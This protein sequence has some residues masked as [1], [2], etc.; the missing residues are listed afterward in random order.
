MNANLLLVETRLLSLSFERFI[1]GAWDQ[2]EGTE[3]IPG[4]HVALMARHLQAAAKG[5]IS[6]LLI[7]VPPECTKS[8]VV[9][10]LF[11]A[12]VWSWKPEARFLYQSYSLEFTLRDATNSRRLVESVWYRQRWPHVQL[13]EDDNRKGYYRTTAGGYRLSTTRGSRVT[14]EHPDFILFEDPLSVDQAGSK[15]EREA[16]K[17]W[18]R[19]TISSRGVAR[20]AAHILSQQRLHPDDPSSVAVEQNKQALGAGDVPPWHHVCL[21]MRF[22]QDRAM[23]DRGYGGDWR[24]TDGELLFPQVF[25][26]EKVK[27]NERSMGP[28]ATRAQLQQ[29]PQHS[30]GQMFAVDRLTANTIDAAPLKLD[31]VVRGWDRAASKDSGCYSAGVLLGWKGEQCFIL[32]VRR[33]QWEASEVLGQMAAACTLDEMHYTLE[34]SQTVVEQEPGSGGKESAENA[35]KRLKG[36]R[37]QAVRP[38]TNKEARAEPLAN[39]IAFGEVYLLRGPWNADFLE[40]LRDFPAGKYK[41]QVDAA[42]LAYLTGVGQV[43]KQAP[44]LVSGMGKVD[45]LCKSPGCDR[46]AADDSEQCCTCCEITASFNDASMKVDHSP[47][48]DLRASRYF[49]KHG[50]SSPEPEPRMGLGGLARW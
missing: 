20:G 38:T 37:V 2:L 42:A 39:A 48:C 43:A 26:E 34:R 17:S 6:R 47:D 12:W 44:A 3:F 45:A 23:P 29:D 31:K 1:A 8:S 4:N 46:P 25:T 15:L 11:P 13:E 27:R 22:E 49:N 19:E 16:W 28:R 36:H 35:I 21:P 7:N 30:V 33:G 14:G 24:K 9:A 41:D 40:E 5:E 32:D 50:Y 10:I 18:Y